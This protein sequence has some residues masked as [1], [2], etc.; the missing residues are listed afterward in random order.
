MS[1]WKPFVR[2]ALLAA[3]VIISLPAWAEITAQ[4]ESHSGAIVVVNL[5]DAARD[6]LLQNKDR[7][8]LTIKGQASAL[9][10]PLKLQADETRLAVKPRFSLR[11]GTTYLLQ[12]DEQQ[13]EI[14]PGT[15]QN[16][17]P[18]LEG[19]A[20]SQ[21]VLPANTLRFYLR[22]SEPMARGQLREMVRL[23]RDDGSTVASP[24][25]NLETE[26][27]DRDQRRAT[28]LFDPGRIKQGVGP[29]T[30]HGAPLTAGQSYRLV[31][32]DKM[33][34]ARGVAMIREASVSFR[35]GPAVR[36]AIYPSDWQILAPAALTHGLFSIAFDRIMDS[37][38]VLRLLSLQAP[39][40]SPI[41]GQVQSDGGG[42]S[43]NPEK[44]WVEGRYRLILNP[45]L[46]D[47]SGNT[48]GI[49]FD[50]EAEAPGIDNDT[51]V[52]NIDITG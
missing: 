41:R 8:R 42:W 11:A 4:Y 3:L 13:L 25:L 33:K 7:V 18:R 21:A 10:M 26:L 1:S 34:S 29:N 22:F 20:P 49:P 36:R 24:F 45:E 23:V 51:L 28:I 43:L 32:S 15:D 9:G 12:L 50:M 14:T 19:F 31:V 37:G 27:W 38:A 35:V 16:T 6:T 48:P 5:S 30:A 39:D 47:I 2:Q 40:G 17:I 46:E 44:P 52:L